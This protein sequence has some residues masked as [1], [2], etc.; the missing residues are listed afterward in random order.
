MVPKW[1][2]AP[3]MVPWFTLAGVFSSAEPPRC[4][5]PSPHCPLWSKANKGESQCIQRGSGSLSENGGGRHRPTHAS[6]YARP[7]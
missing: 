3:C 7:Q 1:L 2:P 5:A 4:G 6:V